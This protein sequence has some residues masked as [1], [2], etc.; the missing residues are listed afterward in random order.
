MTLLVGVDV[1]TTSCKAGVYDRRGRECSRARVDMP[2]TTVPTGA[3]MDP[4]E[5]VVT[6]ST[7]VADALAG[8]PAGD[9]AGLGV[10]SMAE[11][12][13]L[14]DGRGE[15]VAPAIAWHDERGGADAEALE[16]DTGREAFVRTT[17]LV[18]GPL[19]T[20]SKVRW[21][22]RDRGVLRRARR[23]FNVAEWV[24]E[25]LGGRARPELSL[26]SRT[27]WLDVAA[28]TWWAPALAATGTDRDLVGSDPV[29]A[30][31]PMG[32]VEPGLD[33]GLDRA[34]GAVL[35]VAGHDH[36]A[37]AVGVD[38]VADGDVFDSCGTAE[39]LIVPVPPVESDVVAGLVDRGISV[40]RH[41]VPARYALLGSQR[42][43]LALGRFLDLLGIG[44][45]QHDDL[46][47][48][49]VD[50]DVGHLRVEGL[51]QEQAVLH[52]IGWS[53]HPA[54]IWRAAIDRM[55]ATTV[56][57]L[58]DLEDVAGVTQRLVIGGGWARNPAVVASKR[59]ALGPLVVP[60]VREPGCRGAALLGGVAAGVF[61]GVDALPSPADRTD[62]VEVV[63]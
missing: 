10:T 18:P 4:H 28:A 49:A 11:T 37:G 51:D 39:A 54:A 26:S 5:L 60:D 24:V 16:A 33:Q 20:A 43:G 62:R 9:I 32:A 8:A 30:G 44:Q 58:A 41:V 22:D 27:G 29:V 53:P 15:P 61:A 12:G 17:G 1:G 38:A 21:L 42:A 31:T 40:G 19:C 7:A 35:T 23:W 48:A 55:T 45:D 36:L 50:V 2:W 63:G 47:R 6:A 14:V 3:E 59:A 56:D 25:G 13:V 52:G 57:I 34:R 46:D